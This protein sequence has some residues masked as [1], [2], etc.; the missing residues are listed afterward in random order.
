MNI[1]KE[2]SVV[3][4]NNILID[5]FELERLD[6]LFDVFEIVVIP[7]I[8]YEEEIMNDVKSKLNNYTF[9]Q[10]NIE[11]E[12]GMTLYG[13]LTQNT[14]YKNLSKHDKFAIALAKQYSYFC[15]S[16]DGLVRRACLEYDI[17]YLG[18]LGV[19]KVGYLKE[20]VN[21]EEVKELCALLVS[22][23]TS[24]YISRKIVEEFLLTFND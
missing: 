2:L 22:E 7:R 8:I 6:L 21:F 9:T 19:F 3:V 4:D 12:I 20:L 14:K 24:C 13:E 16:N 18:I 23:K 11:T 10:S 5:L 1:S 17:D 15:N